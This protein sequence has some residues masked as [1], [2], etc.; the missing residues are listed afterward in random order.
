M[1]EIKTI[2]MGNASLDSEA[3][4]VR[5]E[6]RFKA[7]I[8]Y[9]LNPFTDVF[10]NTSDLGDFRAHIFCHQ[11]TQER[12]KTHNEAGPPEQLSTDALSQ[13]DYRHTKHCED[14]FCQRTTQR[15]FL[16]IWVGVCVWLSER[17]APSPTFQNAP[18]PLIPCFLR[19]IPR[20]SSP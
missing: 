9:R 14:W 7:M 10:D 6:F 19:L 13:I 12:R 5:S 15:A 4:F 17:W 16:K 18:L 3:S 1:L 8:W 20:A 2:F 11:T